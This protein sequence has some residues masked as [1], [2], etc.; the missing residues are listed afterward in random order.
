M[1]GADVEVLQLNREAQTGLR[2]P[3][4]LSVVEGAGH[5]FEE[6]GTLAQAASLASDWFV[7]HLGAAD[8]GGGS[9]RGPTGVS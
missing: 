5:L 8:L 7:H 6:P 2:C 1:G 3:N 9:G 4:R